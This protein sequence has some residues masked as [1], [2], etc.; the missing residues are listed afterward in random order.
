MNINIGVISDL[1]LFRKTINIENALSKLQ[2]VD[3]LCMVGDIA[4]RAE[5]EQY[6]ILLRLMG[7]TFRDIPVYC[8]SGNHDNPAR[9]DTAYRQFEKRIN[10]QYP[11]IVD[12]SGAFFKQIHEDVALIGL[13]PQYHQKQFYFPEKGKQLAFLQ[14][15]LRALTCKYRI[16]LCHP[17]LLAHNPH[18]TAEMV[19]YI[20]TEQDARLQK[21][22]DD[23]SNIIFLS[24]HTHIAPSIEF[25]EVHGNL[26]INDGS[27]CPTTV[28][29]TDAKVQQGNI[30]LLALSE[31]EI[32][33][34]VKGIFSE[35]ILL[36]KRIHTD[37]NV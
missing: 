26:Y 34:T 30:T 1:H 27:I 10:D 4:D 29:G 35:M 15:T 9:D 36:E 33:V 3:I 20:V 23:N 18:R 8:V 25:D 5:E 11:A 14:E 12:E 17:P 19:S 31:H 24:G 16:V 7:D 6:N 32:C 13:N 22:M 28:K 2:H 37:W 21:I